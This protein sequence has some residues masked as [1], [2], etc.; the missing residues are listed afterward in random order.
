MVYDLVAQ[1]NAGHDFCLDTSTAESILSILF[2]E[3]EPSNKYG[4]VVGKAIDDNVIG[5]LADEA[6]EVSV[7]VGVKLALSEGGGIE[8]IGHWVFFSGDERTGS[9]FEA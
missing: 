5:V 4:F 2:S 7:V 9:G 1:D 3:C 6:V 8:W